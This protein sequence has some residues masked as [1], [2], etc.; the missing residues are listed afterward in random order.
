MKTLGVLLIVVSGYW[1]LTGNANP[2]LWVALGAAIA[3]VMDKTAG[4]AEY[5]RGRMDYYNSGR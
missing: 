1:I 2:W 5:L 4:V 3:M